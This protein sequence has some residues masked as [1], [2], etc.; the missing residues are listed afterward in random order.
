MTSH[1]MRIGQIPLPVWKAV[2]VTRDGSY[3]VTLSPNRFIY[4][5]KFVKCILKR[6]IYA[7]MF[8]KFVCPWSWREV[9]VLRDRYTDTTED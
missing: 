3:L 8:D 5:F 6:F 1:R 9:A 2:T 4:M 7:A